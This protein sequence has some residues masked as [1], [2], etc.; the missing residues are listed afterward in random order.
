LAAPCHH[1]LGH[2]VDEHLHQLKYLSVALALEIGGDKGEEVIEAL[3]AGEVG[4]GASQGLDGVK[5]GHL[6]LLCR[7][8]HAGLGAQA[9]GHEPVVEE[10]AQVPVLAEWPGSEVLQVVDVQIPGQVAVG[11]VWRQEKEV[12][13]LADLVRLLLMAGLGILLQVGV[14][15][16]LK[17]RADIYEVG[18]E[19]RCAHPGADVAPLGMMP[20]QKNYVHYLPHQGAAQVLDAHPA[21]PPLHLFGY[22]LRLFCGY[23]RTF[24]KLLGELGLLQ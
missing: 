1:H 24:I 15:L 5:Y 4:L 10:V 8:G 19:Y 2:L 14:L 21:H 17:A 23:A 9:I 11:E 6:R 18:V 20:L 13:L 3:A 7:P 12:L 16:G 22:V